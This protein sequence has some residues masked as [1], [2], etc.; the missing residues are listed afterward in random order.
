MRIGQ[1]FA[2]LAAAVV[3][4]AGCVA[5][6][7]AAPTQDE[8]RQAWGDAGKAATQ[9]PAD[10]P[11]AGQAHL[12]LPAGEAFVPRAQA[13]RLLTVMG[14][15]GEDP[16][17]QGLVLSQDPKANWFMVVEWHGEGYVKDDD[18]KNWNA[19]DLLK[20][21]REGTAEGNKEREKMGVPQLDIVGWA[22]PPKYD[23]QTQRLV[24]A[25]S[26]REVG[27]P[28]GGSQGVNYN[29]Y[30]LGRE[31]Y[32]TMNLVAG[33]DELPALKPVAAQLLGALEFDAGKR[34]ADFNG[35]TDH[36]AEY[37]LAALVVGV[38]A[39]KLGL[40]ALAGVFLAKFAKIIFVALALFGAS[41]AK[42]FKRKPAPAPAAAAAAP[43]PAPVPA[44]S[45]VE[46][47]PPEFPAMRLGEPEAGAPPPGPPGAA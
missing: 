45:P 4:W 27:A 42:L 38:A 47:A 16:A 22:E 43:A 20:S 7:L 34:Y 41:F 15:P 24:W 21:Y 28:A 46:P 31:G 5:P 23:A 14:N 33:L 37:G 2:V 29:T 35:K 32:F 25:M 6:A 26:S 10:V 17:L 18:A 1:G 36:V 8:A 40:V 13:V 3:A 39:H 12:H 9:G 11:L 44:P 30:A 19:D